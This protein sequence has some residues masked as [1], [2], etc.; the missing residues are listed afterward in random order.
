MKASRKTKVLIVDD[1]PVVV[2]GCRAIFAGD[3]S[4]QIVSAANEREGFEAYLQSRPHVAIID[5]NLPDL[6]GYELLRKIRREDA[7][8]KVIMFSVN[9]DPAFVVRAVELGAKGFVCKGDDPQSLV[10]AVREVTTGATFVSPQLAQSVTFAAAEARAH[11][12]GQLN[13]RELEIL[14][15]L[16]R[17]RKIAQIADALGLSYKTI[18]NTTTML[19]HKLGAQ[20]HA[21][22]VRI[23][24]E[25]DIK[26]QARRRAAAAGSCASSCRPDARHDG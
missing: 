21:D 10:E 4:V 11:P 20:T 8:A 22:L 18:A 6:S 7:T 12:A 23:A 26:K 25:F 2:S 17:G 1:H 16:A 19:K 14:R 9:E 13:N 3:R 24:V 15:L 5:I